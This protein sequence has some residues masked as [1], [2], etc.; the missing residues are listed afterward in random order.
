MVSKEFEA[1]DLNSR[2]R[3]NLVYDSEADFW[4]PLEAVLKHLR[5]VIICHFPNTNMFSFKTQTWNLYEYHGGWSGDQ[6]GGGLGLRDS[7]FT[8]PQVNL[9][10]KIMFLYYIL[11]YFYKY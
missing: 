11:V 7:F 2:A 5:G 9:F 1:I 3:L 4:I 6:A 8:N 10:L